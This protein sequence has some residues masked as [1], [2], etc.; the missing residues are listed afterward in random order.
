MDT[1]KKSKLEWD[2]IFLEETMR[3]S[4][5]SKDPSTKVGALIVSPD[6]RK[7][8]SGYN[9]F[10]SKMED[11][12]EW[13]ED[14]NEKYERI[15]HGEMNA[16][17][18]AGADVQGYTLY[19]WPFMSCHRCFVHMAQAG[20]TRFV[21]PVATGDAAKRWATAFDKTRQYAREMSLVV[22]EIDCSTLMENKHEA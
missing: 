15:I 13:Y 4:F 22:E 2:L 16:L 7:K 3:L 14:R 21:S 10:P 17:I 19:T 11:Q 20:I 18:L 6:R 5:R 1:Q 12:P 8:F 9:G